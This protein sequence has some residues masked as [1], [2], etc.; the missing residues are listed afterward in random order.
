MVGNRDVQ[1][2][3]RTG[4]QADLVREAS[5]LFARSG[6]RDVSIADVCR[7]LGLSGPAFYRHFR[8]K[9][10]L[11]VA[12]LD[13]SIVQHLGAVRDLVV[14]DDEPELVLRRVVENHVDFVFAQSGNIRTWRTDFV[15]LPDADRNR[16]RHLQRLY[17]REWVRVLQR[18][19]P[20]LAQARAEALTDAAV[21]LL[22]AP[23]EFSSRLAEAEHRVLL[24]EA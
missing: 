9:E 7:E 13:D 15:A 14:D 3:E 2:P 8:S 16:L 6:Y 10:E 17:T 19:R 18:A 12:V 11:L 1:V 23:T 5:R 20:E 21:S 22:Q 24:C 4:R